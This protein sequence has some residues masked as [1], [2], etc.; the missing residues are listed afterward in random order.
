MNERKKQEQAFHDNLRDGACGQRWSLELEKLL[1]EDP[2]W[3]NM[4]Y[5]SI[6]RE[7]RNAVIDWFSNNCKEKKFWITAAAMV[8]I[9]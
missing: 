9:V 1:Q 2:K 3:D 7:S 4:K 8:M 6:E 5:Y